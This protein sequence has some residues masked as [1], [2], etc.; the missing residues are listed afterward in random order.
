MVGVYWISWISSF[1]NT[2]EPGVVQTLRPTSNAVLSVIE[3]RPDARSSVNSR[4]PSIR[5]APPVSIASCNAS[6]LVASEFAGLSA[7]STWRSA[8]PHCPLMRSST[9]AA[10][11]ALCM[12]S[13]CARYIFATASKR[14]SFAQ[15]S[16]ANRRS[17]MGS[18]ATAVPGSA[19][20]HGA[21]IC[22]MVV[23]CHEENSAIAF[24]HGAAAAAKAFDVSATSPR[25]HTK[26]SAFIRSASQR[27]GSGAG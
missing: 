26:C 7:S 21:I 16:P 17:L 15:A 2:T 5:L 10:S 27:V 9:G 20:V 8:N 24:V 18:L 25:G 22:C 6:G 4:M 1:W 11:S 13:L 19:A 12:A 3:I 14:G 23:S